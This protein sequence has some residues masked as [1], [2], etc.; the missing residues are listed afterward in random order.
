MLPAATIANASAPAATTLSAHRPWCVRRRPQRPQLTHLHAQAENI[1]QKIQE[2][3][4]HI[5]KERKILEASQ[6]LRR[7][8]QNQD[9]LS[10]NEAKIRETER[11]LSYFEETLREL[12]AR[13]N[14][15]ANGRDRSRSDGTPA[16]QV[17]GRAS[18]SNSSLIL[19]Q[20]PPKDPRGRGSSDMATGPGDGAPRQNYTQLDLIKADTPLT[21][22]K[23]SRMLHQLEFKL[24]VEMQ[25]KKGID[26][27]AKL[28]Q[29][30]GDKRS[31]ADA[32]GKRVESERKIQLLQTALK[33]K[34]L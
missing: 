1:D 34:S 8:T 22:A 14:E 25:Y 21:P 7:A 12:Q 23:I 18:L 32:E 11:S 24:Q 26:K 17:R 6:L 27:M 28:Y 13:K 9:V 30:E 33:I 10:R 31:K 2:V 3:Y 20:V 29:A 4:K 15:L 19:L 16:P 5:Q